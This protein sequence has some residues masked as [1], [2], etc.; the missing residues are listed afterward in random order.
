MSSH[1]Y[2][3]SPKKNRFIGAIQAG[4]SLTEAAN[5]FNI[6]KQTASDLWKKFQK[7]G[8]THAHPR[9]GRPSKISA[10]MK[11][12]IVREARANRRK[13]LHKIGKFVTPNI[14]ASSVW[15][16]LHVTGMDTLTDTSAT[17][18]LVPLF[19]FIYLQTFHPLPSSSTSILL[20]CN[21]TR[22]NVLG[23]LKG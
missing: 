11:R 12:T 16:I 10:R 4:Q 23:E 3:D 7:T 5:N 21:R 9:S 20:F 14:S 2:H 19:T 8:S 22:S 15:T 13:P 6:P 18:Y 1:I 17:L